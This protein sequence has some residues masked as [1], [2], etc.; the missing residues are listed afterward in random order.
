MYKCNFPPCTYSSKRESNCKQH[1]EKAHGW[2]YVRSKSNG[3]KKDATSSSGSV[4][5]SP[6]TP[7]TPF[8]DTPASSHVLGTPQSAFEPSPWLPAENNFNFGVSPLQP[9]SGN[10]TDRRDSI[11]TAGTNFTN[12]SIFSPNNLTWDSVSPLDQ[13]DYASAFGTADAGLLSTIGMQQPT[14]SPSV[15]PNF[16]FNSN[17]GD[18]LMSNHQISPE[19]ENLT[20]MSGEN[21]F[22]DEGY[23]DSNMF[24]TDFQLYND[25]VAGA[26]TNSID[27]NTMNGNFDFGFDNFQH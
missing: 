4:M 12:P 19:A 1:M 27:W 17:D 23:V 25:A 3:R 14:P 8:A 20:L 7:F 11:T 22:P 9:T 13:F 6:S 15:V 18:A 5:A 24:G 2:Q 16:T 10:F 21:V 26:N